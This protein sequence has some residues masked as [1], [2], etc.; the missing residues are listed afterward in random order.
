MKQ[1]LDVL[2]AVINAQQA[3][4]GEEKNCCNDEIRNRTAATFIQSCWLRLLARKEFQ[5]L[6]NKAKELS[7]QLVGDSRMNHLEE[8][9]ND[10]IQAW[11]NSDF[12]IKYTTIQFYDNSH[13]SQSYHWIGLKFYVEASNMFV[14]LGLKY[15]FNWSLARHQ[16]MGQQRLYE[17][18]HLLYF[19]LWTSYLAKIFF[20][21]GC[22]SLF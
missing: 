16:K 5:R 15:H 21:K 2:M 22:G 3:S 20:L 11:S 4:E 7:I 13:N 14:Y 12:D 9:G 19:D 8:R 17:F 10:T 18:C 1:E 6:Q